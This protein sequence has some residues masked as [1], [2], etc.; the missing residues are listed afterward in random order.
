MDR[1]DL[2]HGSV[3]PVSAVM[4]REVDH[5]GKVGMGGRR[6]RRGL[7]YCWPALRSVS[8][9]CDCETDCETGDQVSQS[10]PRI[11]AWFGE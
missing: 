9:L 7:F 5:C 1:V 10:H 3:I 2:Y 11:V 8:S 4:F 6:G